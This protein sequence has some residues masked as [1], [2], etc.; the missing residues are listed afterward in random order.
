M[1]KN[2]IIIDILKIKLQWYLIDEIPNCAADRVAF[3]LENAGSAR[4]NM[5][6][7]GGDLFRRGQAYRKCSIEVG[8]AVQI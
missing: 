2:T 6:I 3:S 1:C 8:I 5:D 4:E 7:T